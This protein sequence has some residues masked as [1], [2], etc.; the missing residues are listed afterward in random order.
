MN[1][2]IGTRIETIFEA[3]EEHQKHKFVGGYEWFGKKP[4]DSVKRVGWVP[5]IF[6]T[7][8]GVIRIWNYDQDGNQTRNLMVISCAKLFEIKVSQILKEDQ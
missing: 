3:Y 7:E 1:K 2:V 4:N 8:D 6:D 5:D